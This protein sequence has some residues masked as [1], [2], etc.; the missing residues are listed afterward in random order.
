MAVRSAS[1]RYATMR[2]FL[3][4]WQATLRMGAVTLPAGTLDGPPAVNMKIDLVIPVAGR[5]GPIEAQLLHELPDGSVALRVPEWPSE[6]KAGIDALFETVADLRNWFVET[7]QLT[8]GDHGDR[9]EIERLR[10]RI[11]QLES[12]P[13]TVVVQQAGE[14]GAQSSGGKLIVGYDEEGKPIFQRGLPLPDLTGIAPTLTG[15]LGDRSLRDA[16]MELAM[17]RV[18]GLLTVQFDDGKTRFGY[19]YRGGPVGFRTDPSAEDE[20]LGVLLFRAGQLKREQ[21]E[22][23]LNLMETTGVRQGEALVEMGVFTFAQLVLLLQKQCEFIFQRLMRETGGTWEFHVLDELPERFIAPPLRAPS[24]LFRALRTHA[25]DLPAEELATTLRPWLDQYVYFVEG[26]DRVFTEMKLGSDEQGFLKIVAS[27]SY[28]LRELFAVSNLP[29]SATAGM[30]WTLADLHLIEFKGGETANRG[31]ERL[32]RVLEDRKRAALR[33]T[34]FESLDLHWICTTEEVE[35][36]WRKLDPEF[37]PGSH[38]RWGEPNRKLVEELHAKLRANYERLKVDSRRREYR[39]EIMERMQI[40]QSAE[41]LAKKGD[42]AFMK[43]NARE[44]FDCFSKACEL[45]PNNGEYQAGLSKARS[46]ARG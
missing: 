3:E 31:I 28:R 15:K 7:G 18:T 34:L 12:R 16:V 21:L 44:A 35:A 29:R 23:S 46:I 1:R 33:G 5:L 38:A 22:E 9:G 40:D 2:A 19:W 6:V 10:A 43:D 45:V 39:A 37:G 11:R 4:D 30:V 14:G 20:V 41:M 36:A 13:Q 26:A 25:K 42:M 17:E 27:T 8:S 32:A 24:M